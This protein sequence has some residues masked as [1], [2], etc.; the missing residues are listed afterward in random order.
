[1]K[2]IQIQ[3]SKLKELGF[4]ITLL[5]A[6]T[7]YQILK[8]P[9]EL[10]DAFLMGLTAWHLV[11]LTVVM[12]TAK[13]ME[14]Y[15]FSNWFRCSFMK[16]AISRIAIYL[17]FA[18]LLSAAGI[19]YYK[20]LLHGFDSNNLFWSSF[21]FYALMYFVTIVA[22]E[23]SK[24]A[25]KGFM[26]KLLLG[27]YHTPKKE[28]RIFLFIDLK[29][30]TKLSK[31]LSL[32]K[33]SYLIKEFFRD[34]DKA[35]EK[36]GGE[37][38]Q[39]AGDEVIVSWPA[40]KANY[41]KAVLSFLEFHEQMKRKRAFYT[42]EYGLAPRFKAAMHS[43]KV[44]GTWVGKMKRELVFQGEVLNITARIT[45]LAKN[46]SYPILL[47]QQVVNRLT[48]HIREQVLPGGSYTV[49]GISNPLSVYF[50]KLL[51]GNEQFVN[52]SEPAER[53]ILFKNVSRELH[54][55]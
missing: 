11:A 23:V 19:F 18:A 31:E 29:E 15:F 1:M 47:T 2:P 40:S 10:R 44:V 16:I 13:F 48:Q 20:T 14:H 54:A 3:W 39:Y 52:T 38:Y 55:S 4:V 6:L 32:E 35:M 21:V 8:S 33:Y 36:Y 5:V 9:A 27:N 17:L 51:P 12:G 34:I 41:D 43:G 7:I 37:I 30:S 53:P 22:M 42:R 24:L 26:G 46:L 25:G 45:D 49:K 28:S 50:L